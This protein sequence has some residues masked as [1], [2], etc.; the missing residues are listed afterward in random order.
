[1]AER[2]LVAAR[3]AEARFRLRRALA[4]VRRAAGNEIVTIRIVL[5]LSSD[6]PRAAA[7]LAVARFGS[8]AFWLRR[9]LA[10]AR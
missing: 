9:V 2:R 7:R 4:I 3:L 6:E 10:V 5:E 1:M 8:D